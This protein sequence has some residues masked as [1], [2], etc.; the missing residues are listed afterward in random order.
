LK[1]L[2][3]D[4]DMKLEHSE[5]VKEQRRVQKE[6]EQEANAESGVQESGE[7]GDDLFGPEDTMD[8]S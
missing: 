1:K 2:R 8:L 7:E 5:V 6:Q 4:L 3:A